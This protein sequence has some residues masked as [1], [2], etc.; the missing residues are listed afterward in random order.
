MRSLGGFYYAKLLKVVT[1]S[2]SSWFAF[3]FG[4]FVFCCYV[5]FFV[6]FCSCSY[7]TATGRSIWVI[8]CNVGVWDFKGWLHP[9]V[10]VT[11][12]SWFDKWTQFLE[13]STIAFLVDKSI[14]VSGCLSHHGCLFACC[15]ACCKFYP[16]LSYGKWKCA[17]SASKAISGVFWS[18]LVYLWVFVALLLLDINF[19]L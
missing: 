3:S 2:Y 14:N 13:P 15:N 8:K 10:R 18:P 6:G 7:W 4:F 5:E 16:H 9:L 17:I 12:I 11:R 19:F 1:A